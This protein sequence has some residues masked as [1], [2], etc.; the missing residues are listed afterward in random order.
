MTDQKADSHDHS[1]G[2]VR[3]TPIISYPTVAG[4]ARDALY[5][6][7]VGMSKDHGFELITKNASF[8]YDLLQ[9]ILDEVTELIREGMKDFTKE[10]CMEP[11]YTDAS[12]SKPTL[13]FKIIDHTNPDHVANI[14]VSLAHESAGR[15][16]RFLQVVAADVHN[17]L[18]GEDGYAEECYQSIELPH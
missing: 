3:E 11:F 15:V 17:R 16:T 7:T 13:R 4:V 6:Y 1:I 2:A 10:F 9:I 14:V 8:N 18:P 5:M 12:D